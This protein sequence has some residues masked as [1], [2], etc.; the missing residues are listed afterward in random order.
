MVVGDLKL[1]KSTKSQ[2]APCY[3]N[4]KTFWIL[5]LQ[6]LMTLRNYLLTSKKDKRKRLLIKSFK[7][8]DLS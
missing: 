5:S 6:V 1:E 2:L 8:L 3:K 7:L 4:H